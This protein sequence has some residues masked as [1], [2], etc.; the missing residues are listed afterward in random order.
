MAGTR[1]VLRATARVASARR[2][3]TAAAPNA[4][5]PAIPAKLIGFR[6]AIGR[7]TAPVSLAT[8]L[9]FACPFSRKYYEKVI[10]EVRARPC[11]RVERESGDTFPPRIFSPD[12]RFFRPVW[13]RKKPLHMTG[14]MP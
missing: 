13:G 9:C 7:D 1:L 3:V 6:H 14:L 12:T 2:A 8:F 4:H 10:N 11:E 5:G